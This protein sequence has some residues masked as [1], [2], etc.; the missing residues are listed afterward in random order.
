MDV[1]QSP[2]I[3]L[4]IKWQGIQLSVHAA[5]MPYSPD[6]M[7][8]IMLQANRGWKQLLKDTSEYEP[9][10]PANEQAD[11]IDTS[12]RALEALLNGVAESDDDCDED[13]DCDDCDEDSDEDGS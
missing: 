1:V 7:N 5:G 2:A 9:T 11:A 4:Q 12:L 8:D 13:C 10:P 6:S 3:S